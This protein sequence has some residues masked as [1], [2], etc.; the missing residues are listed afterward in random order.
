MSSSVEQIKQRLNVVDVVGSYVKLIKAGANYK[1][2]CP[3]HSEKSPSFFV[4]PSRDTWH[5]FGCNKGGDIFEFVKQIEGVEFVEALKILADRAGV[6]LARENPE[7]RNERT[8]LLEL[9]SDAG[10]FYKRCLLQNP[11]VFNYLRKR[12][13]SEETIKNFNIGFAPAEETGWRHLLNFLKEKGYSVS[14]MEKT[15]MAVKKTVSD[16]YD[17]FRGRIMFPLKDFSGRVVGFSGRIFASPSVSLAKEGTEKAKYI[18]T[19]QTIL[20]DKSKILYGFDSA[21]LEIGKKDFCVLVE[22]QMDVIMS[23]QAGVLN[24]VAVSGTALTENHLLT[25]GRLTKKLVMAFDS[26]EAGIKAS[27]RS[28]DMA[29]S[30]GFEVRAVAITGGKDPADMVLENPENWVKAVGESTHIINFY[31]DVLKEK[32]GDGREYKIEA[33]KNILPYV[34]SMQSEVEKSHWITEI[35]KRIGAREDSV[36]E[37]FKKIRLEKRLGSSQDTS[38]NFPVQPIKKRLELLAERVGGIILWKKDKTLFPEEV[39]K[40]AEKMLESFDKNS[41]NRIAIEAELYYSGSD[42]LD[43]EITELV[44]DFKKE[45]VKT[46]LEAL[47]EEVCS[48]ENCGD[49]ANLSSKMEEFQ[50]LS[51][52]LGGI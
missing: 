37:D 26:D 30:A 18:N 46:R 27:K 34:V 31:L 2:V 35:A 48:Y 38:L 10:D 9:M 22:G 32:Y 36:Y 51:K 11:D 52:E 23:Q 40:E 14:E 12:G 4:S 49:T 15:G 39:M 45:S 6:V 20:Y 5:C 19:P 3:F 33:A 13:L 44:K 8:R 41:K 24:T 21:K 42:K 17:R 47:A 1:A 28:V 7:A 50:K 25:L 43:D 29:L 16:Y